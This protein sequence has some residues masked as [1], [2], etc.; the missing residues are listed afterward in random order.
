MNRVTNEVQNDQCPLY[1]GHKQYRY[2]SGLIKRW[3]TRGRSFTLLELAKQLYKHATA[4]LV[5]ENTLLAL[6]SYAKL[7]YY[8]NST[9][10]LYK[11]PYHLYKSNTEPSYIVYRKRKDLFLWTASPLY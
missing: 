7:F 5:S 1:G 11:F 6:L 3:V 4:I 8:C 9:G 2:M 10:S